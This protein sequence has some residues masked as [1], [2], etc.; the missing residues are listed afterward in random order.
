MLV[1]DKNFEP[2][3]EGFSPLVVSTIMAHEN[4]CFQAYAWTE[5]YQSRCD[6]R[7]HTR[8]GLGGHSNLWIYTDTFAKAVATLID[9]Y[10]DTMHEGLPLKPFPEEPNYRINQA[11]YIR[12]RQK[13]LNNTYH[14]FASLVIE[15]LKNSETIVYC[16][17]PT[18]R[19]IKKLAWQV[20]RRDF[21]AIISWS[22]LTK[23]KEDAFKKYFHELPPFGPI[24]ACELRLKYP[25]TPLPKCYQ[26]RPVKAHH[27]LFAIPPKNRL[28]LL[29]LTITVLFHILITQIFSKVKLSMSA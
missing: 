19:V 13:T 8:T 29:C 11:F 24:E 5:A 20:F 3:Q 12:L 14:Y 4:D 2:A 27:Y 26:P 28:I 18:C 10:I 16:A 7:F 25:A 6:V 17:S 22:H 1:T 21:N 9:P 23:A 15:V